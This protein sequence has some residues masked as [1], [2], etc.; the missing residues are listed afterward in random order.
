MHRSF[1]TVYSIDIFYI[2]ARIYTVISWRSNWKA[3]SAHHILVLV[4]PRNKH[5][6]TSALAWCI[7]L[8]K[9]SNEGSG[10]Q[11]DLIITQCCCPLNS[12]KLQFQEVTFA[13]AKRCCFLFEKV[14]QR[15]RRAS[16]LAKANKHRLQ[17]QAFHNEKI[18]KVPRYI[19]MLVSSVKAEWNR[20]HGLSKWPST[21]GKEDATTCSA[22]EEVDGRLLWILAWPEILYFV[23]SDIKTAW[24]CRRNHAPGHYISNQCQHNAICSAA[25]GPRVIPII[26]IE[27]QRA[28]TFAQ[29]HAVPQRSRNWRIWYVEIRPKIEISLGWS[30]IGYLDV[31]LRHV[32]FISEHRTLR[33]EIVNALSMSSTRSGS[34]AQG[35]GLSLAL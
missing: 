26:P 6:S 19:N 30:G 35:P 3:L 9:G 5:S 28:L 8:R 32:R 13:Q 14:V 29:T 2:H 7:T 33:L 24:N 4:A 1:W 23:R 34:L 16:V 20:L 17:S 11:Y 12:S 31:R 18:L 10:I 15:E 25:G 21:L 27:P 22:G